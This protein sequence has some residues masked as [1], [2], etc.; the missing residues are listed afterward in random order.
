MTV[1]DEPPPRAEPLSDA[2]LRRAKS[3]LTRSEIQE[4]HKHL[5]QKRCELIGDVEALEND[6]R[7]DSGD[8]FSPEHMADI[9][10]NNYDQEFTL[11]LV[12]SEQR[13]LREIDEALARIENRTYGV[14]AVKGTPIGKPRLD[15]KPW[16]KYCIEV[17]REKERMGQM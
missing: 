4:Y 17:A 6:A 15:A 12:E 13:L 8:H 9:G 5:S 2:Q 3:G 1:V 16:A 11:G 14:C 7:T 10:S